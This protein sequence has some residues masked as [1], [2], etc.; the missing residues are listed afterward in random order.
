MKKRD[1]TGVA[2]VALGVILAGAPALSQTRTPTEGPAFDGSPAWFLQGSFP[3]PG[4][5]TVVDP[6]GKVTTVPRGEATG[7][8]TTAGTTPGCSGSPVC[9]NRNGC[10]SS[11]SAAES[12]SAAARQEAIGSVTAW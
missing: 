9:G 3:D 11:S 10:G 6:D 7:Y 8:S 4:G 1:F 5:R 2:A 12:V